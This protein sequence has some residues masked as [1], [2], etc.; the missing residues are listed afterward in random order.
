MKYF[1]ATYGVGEGLQGSAYALPTTELRQQFWEPGRRQSIA[2]EKIVENI[3]RMYKCAESMPEMKFKVAYRNQPNEVTLC[4][5]A[6]KDLMAM[7]RQAAAQIG[8]Y[9]DNVYFSK[10]WV[11]SGLL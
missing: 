9:P 10:E 5:Y 7:F 8:G 1:G 6:G 2:P 11:D 3:V 4:G